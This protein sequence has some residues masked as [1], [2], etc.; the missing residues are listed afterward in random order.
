VK[1]KS[2]WSKALKN[3]LKNRQIFKGGIGE[4]GGQQCGKITKN[5]KIH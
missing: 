4:K 1:R 5:N 3:V 2:K